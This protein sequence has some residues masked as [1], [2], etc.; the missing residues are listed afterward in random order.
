MT[1][2]LAL[3]PPLPFVSVVVA[4]DSDVQ[5]LSQRAKGIKNLLNLVVLVDIRFAKI[6]GDWIKDHADVPDFSDQQFELLDVSLKIEPALSLAVRLD[7]ALY[8]VD[9]VWIAAGGNDAGLNG[10]LLARPRQPT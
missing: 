1:L 5:P 3:V 7:A 6:A 10:V 2:L 9:F 4:D 8:D